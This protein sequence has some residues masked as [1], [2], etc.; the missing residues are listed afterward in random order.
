LA[1]W[2][3]P[4]SAASRNKCPNLKPVIDWLENGCDPLAAAKELRIYQAQM[5]REG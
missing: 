4:E 2:D 1:A 3:A 5:D